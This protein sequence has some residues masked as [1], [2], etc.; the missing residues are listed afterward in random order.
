MALAV[1]H[2]DTVA[3]ASLTA[4]LTFPVTGLKSTVL[5]GVKV[6]LAESDPADSEAL[7]VVQAKVPVVDAVPPVRVDEASV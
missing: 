1:G 6:T 2:A 4:I 5:A 7:E 3:V